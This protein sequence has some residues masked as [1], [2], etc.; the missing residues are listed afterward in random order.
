MIPIRSRNLFLKVIWRDN[1]M[2][3]L[4]AAVR[5]SSA[6]MRHLLLADDQL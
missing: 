6:R 2:L 5:G 4:T 1:A 3:G